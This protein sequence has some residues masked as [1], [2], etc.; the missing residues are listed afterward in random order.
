M[1]SAVSHKKTI[2][3]SVRLLQAHTHRPIFTASAV[4]LA[5]ESADSTINSVIVGQLPQLN[6]FDIL[7]PLE[8]ADRNRPT[9]AVGRQQIGQVGLGLYTYGIAIQTTQAAV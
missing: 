7:N 6:M 3:P 2:S 5:V 4:E 9:I 8:L 1:M